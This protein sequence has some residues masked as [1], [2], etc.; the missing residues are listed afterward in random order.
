M[1][2]IMGEREEVEESED[3]R[4]WSVVTT[5]NVGLVAEHWWL[6]SGTAASRCFG[7]CTNQVLELPPLDVTYSPTRKRNEDKGWAAYTSAS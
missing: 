4:G 3:L 1:R 5:I 2:M 6:R 7:F